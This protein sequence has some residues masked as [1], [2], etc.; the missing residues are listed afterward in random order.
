MKKIFTWF[1][2]KDLSLKNKWWHR[3]FIVLFVCS[4][5]LFIGY[6]VVSVEN[7]FFP[8][9][10]WQKVNTLGERLDS[11]LNSVYDIT[12]EGE[13]IDS[14][15]TS[16]LSLNYKN[17]REIS[18]STINGIST[19]EIYCSNQIQNY[20]PSIMKDKKLDYFY[21][22]N[23]KKLNDG[24]SYDD[25]IKNINENNIKCVTADANSTYNNQGQVTGRVTFLRTTDDLFLG[26]KIQ[27]NQAFYKIS[28]LKSILC[29]LAN[30]IGIL[31]YSLVLF[32][33]IIIIYYKII[34]YIIFGSKKETS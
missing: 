9:P 7:L 4:F 27:N 30:L 28:I 5:V 14:I 8:I 25:F 23:S 18:E 12:N 31:L 33:I 2:R 29:Y 11:K 6:Q 15:N 13:T 22:Y 26:E 19:K 24:I 32:Y 17:E 3:L 20:I 1:L 21:N 10:Q 34:L 16:S